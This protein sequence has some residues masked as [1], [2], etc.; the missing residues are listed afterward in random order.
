M[1]RAGAA[2]RLI[3]AVVPGA[4]PEIVNRLALHLQGG[5]ELRGAAPTNNPDRWRAYGEVFREANE[6]SRAAPDELAVR[7]PSDYG[8]SHKELDLQMGLRIP[9][10]QAGSPSLRDVLVALEWLRVEYPQYVERRRGDFLAVNCQ[11]LT[12]EAWENDEEVSLHRGLAAMRRRLPVP[13]WI[14]QLADQDAEF[15]P[16]MSEAP[17]FTEH[18]AEQFGWMVEASF[19]RQDSQRRYTG[20]L[21]MILAPALEAMCR[22][23]RRVGRVAESGGCDNDTDGRSRFPALPMMRGRNLARNRQKT[24]SALITLAAII[25]RDHASRTLF[26]RQAS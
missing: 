26:A 6:I 17:I 15:W 8:Q 23:A 24:S 9:D 25:S 22:G 19:D 4:T 12:R 5:G 1:L 21:G 3:H 7:L 20:D 18:A 10:L 13:L 14:I 11:R 2:L 16:L